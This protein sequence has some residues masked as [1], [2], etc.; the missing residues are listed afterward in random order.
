M[1]KMKEMTGSDVCFYL[2][3]VIFIVGLIYLI[4]SKIFGFEISFSNMD[5]LFATVTHL[6]CPGCGGTR[7]VRALVS[8][9][10]IK[11]LLYNPIVIVGGLVWAYYYI[12]SIITKIKNNGKV[13]ASFC[14]WSLWFVLIVLLGNFIIRNILLV[15]F[16]VDYIGDMI[17]YWIK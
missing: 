2:S 4:A 3:S 5:C 13:Y 9:H 15:C 1:K 16:H 7:A 6:Y 12:G 8:F 11:S 17:S 10:F 14:E